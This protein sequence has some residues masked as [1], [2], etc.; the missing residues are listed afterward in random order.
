MGGRFV[1][2]HYLS[3]KNS[4]AV[5]SAMLMIGTKKAYFDGT[6]TSCIISISE[7]TKAEPSDQPITL[8]I[9]SKLAFVSVYLIFIY[10]TISYITQLLAGVVLP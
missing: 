4:L 7:A 10:L 6:S 1:I 5:Y 8:R 2:I 3:E 9:G